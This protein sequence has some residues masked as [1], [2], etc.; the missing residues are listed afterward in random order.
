MNLAN[1]IYTMAYRV[2]DIASIPISAINAASITQFFQRGRSGVTPAAK[3][4]YRLLKRAFPISMLLSVAH[5]RS[6][7]LDPADCWAGICAER[8]CLALA[9]SHSG[10][11]QRPDVVRSGTDRSRLPELPHPRSSG[12][13]SS[14]LWV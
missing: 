14:E 4:S 2:V 13:R 1:G 3:L 10:V 6:G 11:S 8:V 7:A 12:G 5:V 9:L